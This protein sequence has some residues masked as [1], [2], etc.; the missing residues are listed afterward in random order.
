MRVTLRLLGIPVIALT[1]EPDLEPESEFEEYQDAGV[2]GSTVVGFT[3]A[4]VPWE[5]SGSLH[6]FEPDD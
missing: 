6:Q 1:V 5:D 2:T 4:E 3:R